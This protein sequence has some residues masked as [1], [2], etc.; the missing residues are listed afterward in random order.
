MTARVVLEQGLQRLGERGRIAGRHEHAALV[1]LHHFWNPADARGDAR[2]AEAHGLEDAE[3]EAFGVRRVETEVG[4][5]QIVL[6]GVDLLADDHAVSQAKAAHVAG[7]RRERFTGENQQLEGA[8]RVNAHDGLEQQVHALAGPEVGGMHHDQLVAE[9]ELAAHSLGRA[10]GRARREEVVND[11]DGAVEVEHALSLAPERV[12][13]GGHGVRRGERVLDGGRVSRVLAEQRGVGPVQRRDHA[14][15]LIRRQHRPG[16][17]RRGRVRHGVVDVQHVEPMVAAHLGHAHR[18]RQG[19]VGVS[20]QPVLVDR[21]GMKVQTRRVRG[22][23]ERALVG[24]EVHVVP[25]RGQLFAER[26]GQ[27][28]APA[29]GRVAGDADAQRLGSHVSGGARA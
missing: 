18:Q 15:P 20:E 29:H 17:D 6:D 9:A 25:A 3:A 7:E 10:A 8:A 21:D 11:L 22:Q 28:A 27:H 19:V 16:E 4:D 1:V 2:A 5:L 24:D 14:R 13:H 23:A 26:G 12:R